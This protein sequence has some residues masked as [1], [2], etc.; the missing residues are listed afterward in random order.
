MR[1][2][3]LIFFISTLLIGLPVVSHSAPTTVLSE[4]LSKTEAQY[5]NMQA[6][7]ADFQQVTTS[8]AGSAMGKTE[9]TGKLYYQR[10]RQMRWEYQKPEKQVFVAN[11]QLAWL[12]APSDEQISLFDAKTF[13][14]SPLAQTFFDGIVELRKHF[15]VN[16]DSSQSTKAAAVLKLIPKQEDPNIKS[17]YLWID[18]ET[19]RIVSIENRDVL[20]NANRITL[21][22]QVAQSHLDPR[23]FQLEIPPSTVVLDMEGRE[24]TPSDIDRLKL[25][26]LP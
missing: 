17:L 19:Y 8:S 20:G 14:S 9:A 10:P 25:K 13:F 5:R 6:F 16:L 15:E 7:T 23:L 3:I 22:S 2:S 26:L 12:H 11:Q 1:F 4:I 21:N 24:L 18:L